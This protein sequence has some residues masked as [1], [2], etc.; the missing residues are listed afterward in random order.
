MPHFL[1]SSNGALNLSVRI[2]QYGVGEGHK[3]VIETKGEYSFK[4]LL[5]I[6]QLALFFGLWIKVILHKRG[7]PRVITE[8]AATLRIGFDGE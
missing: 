5:T 6:S 3:P 1:D 7:S 4:V 8:A 2:T